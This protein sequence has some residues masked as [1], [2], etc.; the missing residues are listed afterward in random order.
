MIRFL[1]KLQPWALTLLRLVVGVSMVVHG[2]EKV[3]PCIF[4]FEAYC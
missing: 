4:Q 1:A 3:I 2:W